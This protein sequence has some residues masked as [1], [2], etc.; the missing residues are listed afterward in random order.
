MIELKGKYADAKIFTTEIDQG[1]KD[2]I[3]RLLDQDFIKGSD[4]RIMP[5]VHA[6]MGCVIGFTADMKDK[7]IPNIV[8]VDIGCGVI[9]IKLG[10]IKVNLAK[11]DEVINKNIPAGFKMH[12]N[13]KYK[14]EK[15]KDLYCY[16]KLKNIDRIEKS[17]GSLGGGN[18]F[19]EL[20]EDPNKNKYL[21]IHSGSRNLGHQVAS[22]YQ[23]KAIDTCSGDYS[24]DLC[25]LTGEL[26]EKYLHDMKICQK[27]AS[28]NRKTMANIILKNILNKDI[29]DFEYFET[30]H[31]YI[32]F[33]DNIIRKGAISAYKDELLLIP[34]NM[35]DGSILGK[36]KGNKDWN[37]SAPHGAGRIL[38]RTEA[39]NKLSMEDF[40][41][42]MKDI[43]STSI[44]KTTLDESPDAYNTME[45]IINNIG[46][47][48]DIIDILKP[49]YNFK[50]K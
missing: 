11:L 39:K 18:H 47:N 22:I 9:T 17:L 25:Y 26:R 24:K 8:G 14:F 13:I 27:Y 34:I 35:K 45:Y 29:E 16:D 21:I 6:G 49:I 10:D 42:H 43:Y 4:V 20:S 1:A 3:E 50:A 48:V 30:I 5:D 46:D 12:K 2:Q 41:D 28:K 37:Y 36:G 38:S 44:T 33:K 23:K 31:N 15:I 40:K 32:N 19:I 7:V